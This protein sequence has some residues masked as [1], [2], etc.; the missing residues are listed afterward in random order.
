MSEI[1]PFSHQDQKDD[2]LLRYGEEITMTQCG[3]S[4]QPIIGLE[5]EIDGR[6]YMYSDDEN[7]EII[8]QGGSLED[9]ASITEINDLL[10]AEALGNVDRFELI[11]A[12]TDVIQGVRGFLN[13]VYYVDAGEEGV[14]RALICSPHLNQY[15]FL[16][17][18]ASIDYWE[19]QGR[20][21]FDQLKSRIQFH[22]QFLADEIH[23]EMP[24]FSDLTLEIFENIDTGEDFL[25]TIQKGDI[26]FL[27]A[28]RS[29]T[30]ED[31]VTVTQIIAPNG[32]QI[33]RFDPASGE[34]SS[35]LFE[36]PLVGSHGEVCIFLPRDNQNPLVP[37]PYSF[38]FETRSGAGL[39]EVQVILRSGRVLEMQTLDF[40]FWLAVEDD[41]FYDQDNLDQLENEIAVALEE[42]MLPFNLRPGKIEFIH[43]AMDELE[44]FSSINVKT[45][46]ADCSYMISENIRNTR[47]LSAGLVNKIYDGDPDAE[48]EIAAIS[49]GSPGMIMASTSPHSCI[50]LEWPTF[51]NEITKF[52]DAI[53]EQLIIFSGIDTRATQSQ[54]FDGLRLNHEIAWRIC[55]HPLFYEAD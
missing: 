13:E 19:N 10:A 17:I 11:E 34:F 5:L 41:R 52:A 55:R 15:F 16:L 48:V 14:G 38:S 27:L 24:P 31:T 25:L 20:T 12:G 44:A 40:N 21:I 46:L 30:Q 1:K 43:P 42:K 9:N 28:A 49:S 54:G 45:D 7:L 26:S 4:F 18:T 29:N 3:F 36:N 2:D 23:H 22:P 32:T 8:L 50:I 47:A 39:L 51:Q 35:A 53:M 33:Y 37:G 6:V